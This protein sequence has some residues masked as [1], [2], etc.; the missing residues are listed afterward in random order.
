MQPIRAGEIAL[1]SLLGQD[2][3]HLLG[4]RKAHGAC[5]RPVAGIGRISSPRSIPEFDGG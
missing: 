3:G 1:N 2:R 5:E 4:G